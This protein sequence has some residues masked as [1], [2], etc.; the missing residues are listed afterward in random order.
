[1]ATT[2]GDLLE[3]T[4]NHPT[5]GTV[6]YFAKANEDHTYETGGFRS[7]DD[8]D[9]V[10][11]GGNMIDKI[12]RKRWMFETTLAWNMNTREELQTL[13]DYAADPVEG[14]WTVSHVNG[15]IW[16]GKG[17]PVGTIP[18]EGNAATVPLK[19]AG[20]GRFLPIN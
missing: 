3:I 16:G 10:D 1:M 2:G 8:E 9:M 11:S 7:E 18:G 13:S 20:G 4:C 19:L 5:L 15:K 14:D 6:T 17:K 12:N